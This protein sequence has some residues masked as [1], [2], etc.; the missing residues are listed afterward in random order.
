[1]NPFSWEYNYKI[2]RL[3]IIVF[4][5]YTVFNL[6]LTNWHFV[7]RYRELIYGKK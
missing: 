6:I 4:E 2:L 7:H 3:V 5:T 1:M